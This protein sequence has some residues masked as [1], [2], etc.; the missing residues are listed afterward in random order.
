MTVL[1]Q[2]LNI[3]LVQSKYAAR[4]LTCQHL[5]GN[6]DNFYGFLHSLHC[7]LIAVSIFIKT[8]LDRKYLQKA[9]IEKLSDTKLTLMTHIHKTSYDI[10]NPVCQQVDLAL[11]LT[12]TD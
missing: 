11:T 2:R 7:Q 4:H 5:A 1:T 8:F 3:F 12:H 10:I 9:F 6:Q